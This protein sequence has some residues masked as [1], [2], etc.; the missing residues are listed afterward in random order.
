MGLEMDSWVQM[1]ESTPFLKEISNASGRNFGG[2]DMRVVDRPTI[3]IY[4]F[5]GYR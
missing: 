3:N 4:H 1:G 5:D 2:H